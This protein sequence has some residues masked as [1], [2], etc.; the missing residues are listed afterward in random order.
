M[1]T[2]VVEDDTKV[3]K[4]QHLVEYHAA[5][6]LYNFGII[7]QCFGVME[8]N[9]VVMIDADEEQRPV[10][11]DD[12]DDDRRNS[13]SPARLLA[14]YKILTNTL[15]WI[16]ELVQ[17]ILVEVLN[18]GS[19]SS[20]SDDDDHHITMETSIAAIPDDQYYMNKY[21]QIMVLI[22]Y[23]VLNILDTMDFPNDPYEYHCTMMNEILNFISYLEILYPIHHPNS[24]SSIGNDN[25][26]RGSA[27]PAA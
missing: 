17:P 10:M 24:N 5:I 20:S 23:H 8:R 2:D 13:V 16:H 1:D 12:D 25:D 14:S 11:N 15:S 4:H 26:P 27:S 3:L 21:L 9:D 22:N 19:S 18:R 7:H 6:I